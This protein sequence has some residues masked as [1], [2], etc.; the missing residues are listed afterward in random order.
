[1]KGASPLLMALLGLQAAVGQDTALV[2]PKNSP[3]VSGSISSLPIDISSL[4]DNRGFAMRPNDAN[5]DDLGSGYPAQYLPA[6]NFTYGGVDFIFPQYQANNGSDNVIAQGQPLDVP[7]G[8]YVGV[9]MLSAAHHAIA[10]G[11]VNAT[12]A[13][14]ST[15]SGAVLVDPFWAYTFPY[16]GDIIFPYYLTNQTIDYNRSSIFRTVTWLDSTQELTGLQLPNVTKGASSGPLGSPEDTRLHIF[17]V[18]MIPAPGDGISLDVQLARSTNT[19]F[20]GTNKVQIFEAIINNVGTEWVLA[21]QS[22]TLTIESDG[23]TT[24][25]PGYIKRLRPGD[26][27]R[28]QIGVVNVDGI[29][30]GSEGT[31]TLVI[32]GSGVS[33]NYN[34]DAIYGIQTFEPTYESIYTHE[35]PPWFN[36]AKYGIFIHWGPYAVPGWGNSGKAEKYAEWYWWYL[37]QGPGTSVG[38]YEYHLET[39]GPNVVYDDFI[40]NFTASA[41]NPKD[42]VDLFADAGATYFVQVSKHHDGYAL[43]DLP[44]NASLRTSVALPPHRDLLAELFDAAAE[45]QPQLHRTTYYSLPEWF[46]PDYAP[47]GFGSWPGGNATNP[48]TNKTEPY[49]GYVPV[50]DYIQDKMLPEMQALAASG[51]EMIWCDIGGPNATVEFAAE[52]FNSNAKEGRQVLINNRCGLPGDFDTP[53]YAKYDAV[54]MRKWET[55]LGMDP[56]SYG[57]NRATPDEAYMTAQAIV[58]GLMDIISK[59]GNFLLD[60]G[61]TANGTI[62]DIEQRNLRAAG[63]WIKAHDEAIFNTT[64]WSITSGEGQAVRFTQTLDA[65]YI[66][67]LYAPNNTLVLTSPVPYLEGDEVTVVGGNM[68]GTVI[69]SE[70][71]NGKLTLKISEDVRDADEYA[72]VFKIPYT[73][74]TPLR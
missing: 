39:Y 6:E 28:V 68:A 46:H 31:A 19:W 45:Y 61:P 11:Y 33:L 69:P 4:R 34:F 50:K 53:E 71:S 16:G 20:E 63:A 32:S 36:D 58:T 23:V 70:L 44:A 10:T 41:F 25:K 8:R 21:N 43:Y 64:Y 15:T 48:F 1:M 24:V 67:T 42:W 29:A 62:I 72:W 60:V 30:E 59:N 55:S 12:Y 73:T 18:S 26:Q 35:S 7:L 66:T 27:A 38:T 37:N 22:V 49:T 57:Y 56:Y 40:A 74:N 54:P 65:F 2:N 5:F 17:A 3:G 9:H 51:S 14:G 47:L 52:Y 13:D